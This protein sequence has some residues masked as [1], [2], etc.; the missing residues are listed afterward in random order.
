LAVFSATA[1][2]Y[3]FKCEMKFYHLYRH[4]IRTYWH[5]HKLIVKNNLEIIAFLVGLYRV[6]LGE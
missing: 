3:E 4:H 1:V 6:I 5:E 2:G